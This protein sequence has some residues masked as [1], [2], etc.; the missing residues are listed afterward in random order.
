M[1]ESGH[2]PVGVGRPTFPGGDRA[3]D[4][5]AVVPCLNEAEA[6]PELYRR[7]S[8]ALRGVVGDRHEIVLVNDGSSDSTWLRIRELAEDDPHV[9]GVDLSRNYGHQLALS[10]GLSVCRGARVLILDADLQDPPELLSEM[11]A[12]MDAGADVVYGRRTARRGESWFKRRSAEAFYRV[13]SRLTDVPIPKDTGDFRLMSRRVVDTVNAMPEQHRFL[14]GMVS[15]IG[16]QQVPLEYERAER[17]AGKTKFRVAR[18]LRFAVDAITSFSIAPLRVSTYLGLFLGFVAIVLLVGTL[19]A[20]FVADVVP[21]WTSLMVVVLLLGAAQLV[22][23]G[24]MGEY[25]GRLY[26]QSKSRPLYLIREVAARDDAAGRKDGR[27]T[28]RVA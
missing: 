14:R 25:L 4:V 15:W 5:S 17:H 28:T 24:L 1:S 22:M 19:L 7:L 11:M 23:F 21:G 9:V 8:A 18:M 16:F 2:R 3:V 27:A 6:L 13:L 12:R 26:M 20:W 10:A